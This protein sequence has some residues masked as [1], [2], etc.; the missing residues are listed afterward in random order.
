MVVNTDNPAFDGFGRVDETMEYFTR[1]TSPGRS[2]LR[3]YLPAR[4]AM[5]L[6]RC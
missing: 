4:V 6:E 5:V 2:R 3:L 1:Y